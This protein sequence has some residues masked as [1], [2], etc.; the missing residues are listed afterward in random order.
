MSSEIDI[1]NLALGYLGDD[2]TVSSLYPPEGSAQAEH[3]ARFYPIA[4]TALLGLHHWNFATRRVPVAKLSAAPPSGF[5]FAYAVPAD[6]VTAIA[7]LDPNNTDEF[8]PDKFSTYIIES[9]SDGTKVIYTNQDGAVLRYVADVDDPTKFD[10]SFVEALSWLLASKLAGPI[11]KGATGAGMARECM[12]EFR[13]WFMQAARI[14][15][16]QRTTGD[17]VGKHQ[18]NWMSGR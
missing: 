4:R 3:C 2:A 1:C 13:T 17:V 12:G 15:S 7:V 16:S 14:D 6:L 10:P 11:I 5:L 9:L 8:N 18:P